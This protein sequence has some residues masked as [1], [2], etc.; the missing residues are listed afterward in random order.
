MPLSE[1]KF[2]RLKVCAGQAEMPEAPGFG[3][4]SVFDTSISDLLS[5]HVSARQST[6]CRE[7]CGNES[8][9]PTVSLQ[10]QYV[11]QTRVTKNLDPFPEL[12]HCFSRYG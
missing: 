11:L 12:D 6:L 1:A 4:P 7:S 9:V 2:V 10:L 8:V 5:R 3:W